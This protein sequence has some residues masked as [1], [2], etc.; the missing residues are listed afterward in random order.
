MAVRVIIDDEKQSTFLR[1]HFDER[2][3][4]NFVPDDRLKVLDSLL[5]QS[6]VQRLD[7]VDLRRQVLVESL[8]VRLVNPIDGLRRIRLIRL[9]HG[10]RVPISI[11]VRHVGEN[12]NQ[13]VFDGARLSLRYERDFDLWK[14]LLGA[15]ERRQRAVTGG[16]RVQRQLDSV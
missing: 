15:I 6:E 2:S 14:R 9:Q 4:V 7:V 11:L 3:N 10:L 1:G 8:F 16:S 5:A 12:I 13:S